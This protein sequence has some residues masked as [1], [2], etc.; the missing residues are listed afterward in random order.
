MLNMRNDLEEIIINI[1][2][3]ININNKYVCII[4]Y[5]D[6]IISTGFNKFKPLTN[7]IKE[8]IYEN[9][10]HTVHA[11]KDAIR[12]IKNKNILK[13]C[14]VYI[15]KVKNNEL[16]QGIPCPMCNN[17][18]KKYNITKICEI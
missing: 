11:E 4:T 9:N 3:K 1:S 15:I 18:L 7:N 5:R 13:Y 10:K 8:S 6:K 12:K 17:L 14:K 16:E 2:K